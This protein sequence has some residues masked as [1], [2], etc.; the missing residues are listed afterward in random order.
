MTYSF[1]PQ[2]FSYGIPLSS[3]NLIYALNT[4]FF[5]KLFMPE[6]PTEQ[7]LLK[8]ERA[9]NEGEKKPSVIH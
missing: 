6:I 8:Y 4:T 9:L 3:Q 2:G 7:M 1:L 5:V